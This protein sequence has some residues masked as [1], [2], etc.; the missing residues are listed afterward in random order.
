MLTGSVAS[1]I[2]TGNSHVRSSGTKS[3][4]P[5]ISRH[6]FMIFSLS[7]VMRQATRLAVSLP[8]RAWSWVGLNM[9]DH[10]VDCVG[11]GGEDFGQCARLDG[12]EVEIAPLLAKQGR[13]VKRHMGRRVLA[14]AG[15]QREVLR[16]AGWIARPLRQREVFGRDRAELLGAAAHER[17]L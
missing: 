7:P 17:G 5:A 9:W 2:W 6:K 15:E 3:G 13:E 12:F 11:D 1:P 10:P 4:S 14:H 16:P 8:S